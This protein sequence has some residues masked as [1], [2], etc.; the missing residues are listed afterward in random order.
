MVQSQIRFP[1]RVG[2]AGLRFAQPGS[3]SGHLGGKV[4]TPL[5]QGSDG[6]FLRHGSGGL[7]DEMDDPVAGPDV[8]VELLQCAAAGDDEVLLYGDVEG[9][10]LEV[11]GQ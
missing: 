11:P 3:E 1:L 8:V 7:S 10:A 6:G 9:R 5:E 2:E 4:G